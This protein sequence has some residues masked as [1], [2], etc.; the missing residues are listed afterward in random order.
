MPT[1]DGPQW[2]EFHI[3]RKSIEE[4]KA[5]ADMAREQAKWE[6]ERNVRPVNLQ[7]KVEL[8]QHLMDA[9]GMH[10][11]STMWYDESEH[12]HVPSLRNRSRDWSG[13]NVPALDHQDLINMH[14]HDHTAGEYASDYP[15]TTMGSSHFHHR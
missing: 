10:M 13:P 9:H 3:P 5:I 8:Q 7:D 14:S 6:Q 12:D 15:H 4:M 11:E 1:P 2:E